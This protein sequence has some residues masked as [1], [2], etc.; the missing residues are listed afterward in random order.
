M[1]NIFLAF[2]ENFNELAAAESAGEA[3]RKIHNF[4]HISSLNF[5][6]HATA[7]KKKSA[8]EE[9]NFCGIQ[10]LSTGSTFKD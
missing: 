7:A 8:D 6:R 10:W 4:I 2:P 1:T 5:L 9:R 3:R